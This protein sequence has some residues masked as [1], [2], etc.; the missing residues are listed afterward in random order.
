VWTPSTRLS[1]LVPSGRENGAGDRGRG[2]AAG[3][4]DAPA[5]EPGVGGA[6]EEGDHPLGRLSAGGRGRRDAAGGK[7]IV[8]RLWT[9]ATGGS[10]GPGPARRRQRSAGAGRK[11][12][13]RCSVR[14]S[15]CAMARW[16]AGAGVGAGQ[17]RLG[18]GTHDRRRLTQGRTNGVSRAMTAETLLQTS[19]SGEPTSHGPGRELERSRHVVGGEFS[20]TCLRVAQ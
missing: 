3:A 15:C 8:T 10:A 11:G 6:G 19:I 14:A 17:E 5:T 20:S 2:W 4:V 13:R 9:R 18:R 1:V 16:R 7:S 12:L